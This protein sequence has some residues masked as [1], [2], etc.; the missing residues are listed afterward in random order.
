MTDII[1]LLST[2]R[3]EKYNAPAQANA[4]DLH[5]YNAL[6][7]ETF[8]LPL[9]Y[10]EIMLRN[11]IDMVFSKQF[12]FDWILKQEFQIGQN[13]IENMNAARRSLV[14][15][16][17]DIN[18]RNNLIAELPFGFWTAFFRKE[19]CNSLWDK[20]PELLPEI[21]RF[22]PN[23][24]KINLA[25]ISWSL[26]AIRQYR[27]KIFH[28]GSLIVCDDC[29]PSCEVMHDMIYNFIKNIAGKNISDKLKGFD[30]FEKVH[31]NSGA[32]TYGFKGQAQP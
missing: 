10:L 8:Y 11:R 6:L 32:I 30:R 9:S 17:K 31:K 12:G 26:N 7:C 23:K 5:L 29:A 18:N 3:L 1:Y 22:Y 20:Y 25:K 2:A 28:Y 19:Y 13:Q 16:G 4:L 14:G 27:N 15:S 21:F 24:K